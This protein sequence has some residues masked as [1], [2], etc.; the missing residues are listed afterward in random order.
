[1]SPPCYT[2]TVADL[3]VHQGC[4]SLIDY[5]VIINET[6]QNT[7]AKWNLLLDMFPRQTWSKQA[8]LQP[9]LQKLLRRYHVPFPDN[10]ADFLSRGFPCTCSQ[11]ES[12]PPDDVQSRDTTVKSW[13]EKK[14]WTVCQRS[15][16][17]SFTRADVS[18]LSSSLRPIS[19]HD[20]VSV[21]SD[22]TGDEETALM[23]TGTAMCHSD[24][25]SMKNQTQ[26]EEHE[27]VPPSACAVDIPLSSEQ[28][29]LFGG[30][31]AFSGSDDRMVKVQIADQSRKTMIRNHTTGSEARN[32]YDAELDLHDHKN[33]CFGDVCDSFTEDV[34]L[35]ASL[36]KTCVRWSKPRISR[37]CGH[38]M[39]SFLKMF[40]IGYCSIVIISL[41]L[42]VGSSL[43]SRNSQ[44]ER[45]TGK[46]VLLPI[47]V[48][49]SVLILLIL[50]V[51]VT[52][53]L[54]KFFVRAL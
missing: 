26:P 1:M 4:L 34:S 14:V 39:R 37:Y 19:E 6:T 12:I 32:T 54:C 5:R 42:L 31:T 33:N 25:E 44:V 27:N 16:D 13:L 49:V 8:G 46:F 11:A 51:A 38:R 29:D 36:T 18:S 10:M 41:P 47:L 2:E 48:I 40:L 24:S 28:S 7:A 43:V 35:L 45:I 15:P 3:L 21:T 53:M 30:K 9:E 20:T 22:M 50:P 52:C 23:R 17:S